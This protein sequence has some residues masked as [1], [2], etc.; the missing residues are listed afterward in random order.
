MLFLASGGMSEMS[1]E[2]IQT[3]FLRI[4]S[5]I[6]KRLRFTWVVERHDEDGLAPSL[7]AKPSINA[8]H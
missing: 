7:H 5:Y 4:N 8:K 1:P 2:S 3:D 6:R